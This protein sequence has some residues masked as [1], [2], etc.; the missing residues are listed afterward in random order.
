MGASQSNY[1]FAKGTTLNDP[2]LDFRQYRQRCFLDDVGALNDIKRDVQIF[3]SMLSQLSDVTVLRPFVGRHNSGALTR[4][5][6]LNKLSTL[7]NQEGKGIYLIYYA[8][9]GSRMG[10]GLCMEHGELVSMR[11]MLAV[12]ESRTSQ[13]EAQR[14]VIVADSCFSGRLIDE[15]RELTRGRVRGALNVAVQSACLSDEVSMGKV[16]TESFAQ[17]VLHN[18]NFHWQEVAK[19]MGCPV[20]KVQHPTFWSTWGG[21][22]ERDMHSGGFS[23]R[24]FKRPT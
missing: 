22:Q 2:S 5:F 23:F 9:H 1:R 21:G 7:V 18:K 10:G 24:L 13:S 3:Q 4:S 15:L 12:W 20:E 6:F 14:L 17:K 8:G 11:D 19:D 16:F